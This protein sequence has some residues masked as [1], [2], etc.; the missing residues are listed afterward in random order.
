MVVRNVVYMVFEFQPP[1]NYDEDYYFTE[2]LFP[3]RVTVVAVNLAGPGEQETKDFFTS[4][5]GVCL[6]MQVY[7]IYIAYYVSYLQTSFT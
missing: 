2:P 5:G 3:Y 7:D 6:I 4:E 1:P